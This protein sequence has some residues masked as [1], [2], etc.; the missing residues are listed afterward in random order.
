MTA[1]LA[2]RLK[3]EAGRLGFAAAG[4]CRPD[5]IP[6]AKAALEGFVE[7]GWQG[8]M[9]WMAERMHWRGDPTALWP[10]ARTVVMLAESYTPDEDP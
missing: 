7:A 2:A 5:A 6:G 1:A 10:A 9:G 4:L 8:E 3:A